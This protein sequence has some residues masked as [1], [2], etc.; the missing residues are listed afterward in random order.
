LRGRENGDRIRKVERKDEEK[1][2][3]SKVEMVGGRGEEREV[4]V[5][6][7]ERKEKKNKKENL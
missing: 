7:K 2:E 6:V 4:E 5:G 1:G 3:K